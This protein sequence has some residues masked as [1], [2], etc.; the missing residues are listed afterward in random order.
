MCCTTASVISVE[1]GIAPKD[2]A[3]EKR[4][5]ETVDTVSFTVSVGNVTEFQNTPNGSYLFLPQ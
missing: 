3:V 2:G 5:I 1:Q 4:V